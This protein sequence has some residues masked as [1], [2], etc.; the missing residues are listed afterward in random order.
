MAMRTIP[1]RG[2]ILVMQLVMC[3]IEQSRSAWRHPYSLQ[4]ACTKML[5]KAWPKPLPQ[6]PKPTAIPR[7]V[8]KY[9]FTL[10]KSKKNT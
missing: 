6:V 3:R 1:P 9:L 7:F 4:S 8:V 2:R 5:K 10:Q